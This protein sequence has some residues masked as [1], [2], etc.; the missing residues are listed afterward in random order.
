MEFPEDESSFDIDYEH[1]VG[2]ALLV[3]PVVTEHS[4]SAS[5]YFPPGVWYDVIDLTK[6]TGPSS[7]TVA[8]PRE[9][10]CVCWWLFSE[11]PLL[12]SLGF[13]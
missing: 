8:A 9:K 12:V 5:V 1:L 2:S 4:N 11:A 3:R 6:Y 10:V 7:T 13:P